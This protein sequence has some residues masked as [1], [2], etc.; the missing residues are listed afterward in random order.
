M[1]V[2]EKL[3]ESLTESNNPSV[4]SEIL[5]EIT[6]PKEHK[7]ILS[8]LINRFNNEPHLL[9]KFFN[10]ES[11][12]SSLEATEQDKMENDFSGFVIFSQFS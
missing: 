5:Y 10:H 12:A 8:F 6:T 11:D 4:V 9:H 3:K 7:E 1:K 2:I